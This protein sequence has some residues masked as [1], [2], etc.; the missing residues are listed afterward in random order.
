MTKTPTSNTQ[1]ILEIVRAADNH[2]TAQEIYE[3]VRHTRPHIGVASVYRILRALVEQ[4]EIKELGASEESHR[5]DG[6]LARHDHAVC[7]NCGALIDLST[8]IL[9][10]REHLWA[11]ARTAG[12]EL[13]SHEVRL[14]GR[15]ANCQTRHSQV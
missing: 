7:T 13:E 11:A 14:Y 10:S 12:I 6:R 15:C 3:A 9:L 8:E 5:Y 1:A 2:P 4:G